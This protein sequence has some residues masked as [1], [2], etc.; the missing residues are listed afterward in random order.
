M[1]VN[2]FIDETDVATLLLMSTCVQ[3]EMT[4]LDSARVAYELSID[5]VDAAVD[6]EFTM[7]IT[8]VL[9]QMI[10]L[11]NSLEALDRRI[12]Q[13]EQARARPEPYRV[14]GEDQALI[15]ELVTVNADIDVDRVYAQRLQEMENKGQRVGDGLGVEQVFDMNTISRM[16]YQHTQ[17]FEK[18]SIVFDIPFLRKLNPEGLSSV[19]VTL[20]KAVQKNNSQDVT[21]VSKDGPVPPMR[22]KPGHQ[23][24]A[25]RFPAQAVFRMDIQTPRPA[26]VFDLD[27]TLTGDDVLELTSPRATMENPSKGKGKAPAIKVDDV[28]VDQTDFTLCDNSSEHAALQLA[29]SYAASA[30]QK[31]AQCG[32]CFDDFRITENPYKASISAT[33][34]SDRN[35]GLQL[36]C[37]HRYCLG[38]ASQYLKTELE[39]GP[40]S[41]WLIS[42][43]ECPAKDPGRTRFTEEISEK[44]LGSQN[45]EAWLPCTSKLSIVQQYYRDLQEETKGKLPEDERM[46]EDKLLFDLLEQNGWVRCPQ[47]GVSDGD[48]CNG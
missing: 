19:K 41:E 44:I 13:L 3:D 18:M 24:E 14:S 38:C 27:Q 48:P 6:S 28:D 42:C 16:K 15:R 12:A 23:F 40:G 43:P 1:E 29:Y 7:E 33:S 46:K 17:E 35:K 37:G 34:S 9:C 32:I 47:C 2:I 5:D 8:V 39:K 11:Q 22:R 26:G 45:M 25:S 20:G 4:E 10:E 21:K 30:H 31:P 36:A